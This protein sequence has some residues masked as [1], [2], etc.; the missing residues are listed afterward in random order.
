LA[1]F[2]R[3]ASRHGIAADDVIHVVDHALVIVDMDP[4]ADPPK[5]LV[6]G[7]RSDGQLLE[8]IILSLADD[9]ELVIRAMALRPT[10]HNLLPQGDL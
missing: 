3:S 4:D 10:F 5:V 1:E 6:I 8:V 9:R 2:H 7:P